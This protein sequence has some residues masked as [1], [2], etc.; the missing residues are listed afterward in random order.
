MTADEHKSREQLLEEVR[1]LRS[2]LAQ[3]RLEEPLRQAQKLEAIGRL[4]GGVA[5]DFNNLLTVIT[6]YGEMMLSRLDGSDPLRRDAVEI[7]KAAAQAADLTSQL[8][9]FGRKAFIAPKVLD[10][11]ALL[12]ELKNRL[13]PLLGK[14]IDLVLDLAPDLG[15]VKMDPGQLQQLV[16]N[17]ASNA[18]DAMQRG[19]RLT[20][21][22]ANVELDD[23]YARQRLEVTAGP[24]A[25]L[26]VSDTGCGMSAEVQ[27]HLF[28]PFCTTKKVAKGTGMGL[29]TVYGM[30]KQSGG[31]IEVESAPGLGSTFKV[32]LPRV[33]AAAEADPASGSLVGGTETI[34]VVENEE[35]VRTYTRLVL[36]QVGYGVLEA[37]DGLKALHTCEQHA[38]PIDL[39]MTTVAMP[40]MLGPELAERVRA[41]RPGLRVLYLSD[42]KDKA[43]LSTDA[44][45]AAALLQKPFTPEALTRTVRA[46]LDQEAT[47]EDWP[48]KNLPV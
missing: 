2:L 32:Y 30:I 19:G 36:Q 4:A 18:R 16:M 21:G 28:E 17:L 23:T 42:H 20:L 46:V 25:L 13:V 26:T 6:G 37:V 12:H 24:Y 1:T 7:L 10:L 14:E 38:G 33:A 47:G 39:L 29:A 44:L 40:H 9:A 34:L 27:A 48:G 35:L 5:H 11:N 8:L 43:V 22:T 3:S 45:G 15:R 31:H 41:L